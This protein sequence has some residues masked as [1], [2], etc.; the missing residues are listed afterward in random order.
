VRLSLP[1]IMNTMSSGQPE[2]QQRQQSNQVLHDVT[3]SIRVMAP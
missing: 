3:P 2:E 1:R